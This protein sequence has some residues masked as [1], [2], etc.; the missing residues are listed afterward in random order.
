MRVEPLEATPASRAALSDLL[1]EAVSGGASVSFLHPLPSAEAQAFWADAFASVARGQRVILGA[2]DGKR[3][4]G[5]VTVR[6]DCAANQP[7][8]AV[9]VKMIVAASHRGR[10]VGRALMRAAEAAAIAVGRTLLVLDTASDGGASAFYEGAGF[11]FAGEIPD[12]AFKPHGGLSGARF[13]YKRLQ[14]E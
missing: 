10:G 5:T 11:Q 13:Y 12:Y 6:L 8:R 3:L 14:P 7:H 4:I 2:W 1:V 9:I